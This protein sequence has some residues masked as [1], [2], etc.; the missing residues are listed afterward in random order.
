MRGRNEACMRGQLTLKVVEVW[1]LCH[2]SIEEGPREIVHSILLV[3][4]RLGNHL[5][6]EV[7]VKE[8][9]Q[10]RLGRERRRRRRRRRRR[11]R[12]EEE[13]K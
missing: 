4:N 3:L 10:V 12:E 1:V 13:A 11:G 9:I 2:P 7:V 8:V 6:I 5:S